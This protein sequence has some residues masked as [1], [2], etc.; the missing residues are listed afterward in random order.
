MNT[1]ARLV[2]QRPHEQWL[3]LDEQ[4]EWCDERIAQHARDNRAVRQA[5]QLMGIGAVTASAAIATVDDFKQ[6][7]NGAQP[8]VLGRGATTTLHWRLGRASES[9]TTQATPIRARFKAFSDQFA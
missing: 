8:S 4:I 1:L 6:F 9:A 5:A 2:I 3:A 7:K